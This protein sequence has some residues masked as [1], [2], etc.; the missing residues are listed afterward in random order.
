MYR[1]DLLPG[2][3]IPILYSNLQPDSRTFHVENNKKELHLYMVLL[4]CRP[5]GR[6][7]EQHD[8]FFGVA[9]KLRDLIPDMRKFW[10]GEHKLHIDVWRKVH[11]IDYSFVSIYDKTNSEGNHALTDFVVNSHD[12]E[13]VY[14]INLGGYKPGDFEEYHKKLLICAKDLAEAKKKAVQDIFYIEGQPKETDNDTSKGMRSHIDDKYEVDD[15]LCVEDLIPGF[16]EKYKLIGLPIA[17][18]NHED[19]IY[20]G[21]LTMETLAKSDF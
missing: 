16:K 19:E 1:K 21:Y 8:V 9:E 5:E 14:F 15:I 11:Q 4:G 10:P 18:V 20:P 7:T 17:S 2:L 13:K 12:D 3:T 6:L